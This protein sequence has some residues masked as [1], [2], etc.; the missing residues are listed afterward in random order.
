MFYLLKPFVNRMEIPQELIERCR[1]GERKAE[2][3]LYRV[4]YGFLMS[5]T[6]RYVKQEEMARELVNIGFCRLL[7]KVDKYRPEAPFQYW[8]RKIMV[9]VLI[10]ENKKEK[11]HYGNHQYV[12]GHYDDEKY[13]EINLAIEKF[14][15]AHITLRIDQLPPASKR[16]FNLFIIDGYS[17][18]EIAELLGI[19]EGTSK[20]HLNAAREKLKELLVKKKVNLEIEK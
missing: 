2:N 20:W 10:N 3:E 13:S 19:S 14:D 11:L 5:I 4:L 16:V 18:Q 1:K 7:M 6:R 17:H 9:N 8:A 12:E 15:L